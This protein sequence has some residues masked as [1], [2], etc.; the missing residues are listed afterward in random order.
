MRTSFGVIQFVIIAVIL[1]VA[2]SAQMKTAKLKSKAHTQR[3]QKRNEART[4]A[5][6]GTH[7]GHDH[8]KSTE[9]SDNRKLE[10]L[11]ALKEA[12][13]LTQEEFNTAW[14]KV[15]KKSAAGL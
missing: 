10:Q 2:F 7:L 14:E 13:L 8:I 9:L 11:K 6:G 4:K 15:M 5:R 3:I 12:G 1:I